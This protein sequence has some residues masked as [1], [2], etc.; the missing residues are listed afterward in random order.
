MGK[1][2]RYEVQHRTI[3]SGWVNIWTEEDDLGEVK[4]QSFATRAEAIAEINEFLDD[5]RS[6]VKASAMAD[7]FKRSDFRVRLARPEL[8]ESNGA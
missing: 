6:A 8:H 3:C 5:V 4:P 2:K 7:C 1:E